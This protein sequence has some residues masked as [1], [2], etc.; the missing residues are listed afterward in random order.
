MSK[1]TQAN[2]IETNQKHPNASVVL[3]PTLFKANAILLQHRESHKHGAQHDGQAPC[4]AGLE[5]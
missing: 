3:F 4:S 5:G 1:Q 2:R